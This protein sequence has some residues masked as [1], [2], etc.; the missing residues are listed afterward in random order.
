MARSLLALASPLAA[1]GLL[2][3]FALAIAAFVHWTGYQTHE[4]VAAPSARPLE[5]AVAASLLAASAL[6]RGA[7]S[8]QRAARERARRVFVR[9]FAEGRGY[10]VPP[11]SS[12]VSVEDARAPARAA[13]HAACGLALGVALS[14]SVALVGLLGMRFGSPHAPP[15]RPNAWDFAGYVVAALAGVL[16][17]A[18][19]TAIGE[20]RRS[21][22]SRAAER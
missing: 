5:V 13:R 19:V 2:G 3:A 4:S 20:A 8:F 6:A 14:S 16:A 15:W 18:V 11:A 9:V 12:W 21:L 10:R 1:A 22:A 7:L 17:H